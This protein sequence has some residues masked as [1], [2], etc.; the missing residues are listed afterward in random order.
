MVAHSIYYHLRENGSDRVE[1]Q[2]EGPLT[3]DCAPSLSHRKPQLPQ[4]QSLTWPVLRRDD[5]QDKLK[6]VPLPPWA[7][8]H[9][10]PALPLGAGP[11][12][13]GRVP[14][15]PPMGAAVGPQICP[16]PPGFASWGHGRL[17]TQP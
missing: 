5:P 9:S 6:Q 3:S 11:A 8:N 4:S 7:P 13:P 16:A 17:I 1:P 2:G 12:G 14:P 15:P 10:L